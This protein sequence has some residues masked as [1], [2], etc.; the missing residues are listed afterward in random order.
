MLCPEA[1]VVLCCGMPRYVAL[2]RAVNVGGTSKLPM[3]DLRAIAT[4]LGY[5]DVATYI[6]SGNLVL[7]SRDSA[8]SVAR[9][10]AAAIAAVE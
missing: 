4:A 3:A 6:Q 7:T 9:D 10:L 2:L 1:C 8:A 5:D